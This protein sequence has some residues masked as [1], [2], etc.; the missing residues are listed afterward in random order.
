MPSL[1]DCQAT[2]IAV[3]LALHNL[4]VFCHVVVV[5]EHVLDKEH[6]W[7]EQI[8]KSLVKTYRQHKNS[9]KWYRKLLK[10]LSGL[11][12]FI[13]IYIFCGRCRTIKCSSSHIWLASGL[14]V[15]GHVFWRRRGFGEWFAGRVG[16]YAFKA[17]LL[18]LASLKLPTLPLI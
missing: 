2:K 16:S 14:P 15:C 5:A 13:C 7:G 18:L 8:T 9:H 10:M 4:P 12:V 17:S 11:N 3:L 1:H 6:R